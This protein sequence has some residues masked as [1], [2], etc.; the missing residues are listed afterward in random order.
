MGG[1]NLIGFS[2]FRYLFLEGI[3][4]GHGFDLLDCEINIR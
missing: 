2:H 4:S 1:L 3:D